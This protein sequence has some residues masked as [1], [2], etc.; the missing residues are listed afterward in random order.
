MGNATSLCATCGVEFVTTA[1]R[2]GRPDARFCTAACRALGER[3]RGTHMVPGP[4]AVVTTRANEAV[5]TIESV[6][7]LDA[8]ETL[9]SVA[10]T[11]RVEA[12]GKVEAVGAGAVCPT[13]LPPL[14]TEHSCPHCGHEFTIVNFVQPSLD[15][16]GDADVRNRYS[17]G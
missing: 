2:R 11:E 17:T 14:G 5:E 12:L 4:P 1:R 10:P 7:S 9:R 6:T 15:R 16:T 8:V 13:P 3:T